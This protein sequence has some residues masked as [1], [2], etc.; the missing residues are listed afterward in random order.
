MKKTL[1]KIFQT[2]IISKFNNKRINILHEGGLNIIQIRSLEKFTG[3]ESGVVITNNK[4]LKQVDISVSNESLLHLFIAID[5][6][7]KKDPQLRHILENMDV[8]IERRDNLTQKERVREIKEAMRRDEQ[9]ILLYNQDLISSLNA[10]EDYAKVIEGCTVVGQIVIT[11]KPQGDPQD[12][13]YN[14]LKNIH[15]DQWSI[16]EEGDRFNGFIFAQ[17]GDSNKWLMIPYEC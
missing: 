15:V 4:G 12:E 9:E 14:V 17:V 7:I 6:T 1:I 8:E 2:Y 16:N 13:N 11:N 10:E 3:P 5:Q